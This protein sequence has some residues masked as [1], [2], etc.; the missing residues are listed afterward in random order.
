M[1]DALADIQ[2]IEGKND[3]NLKKNFEQRT[4]A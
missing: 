3:L 4:T 2:F 1:F